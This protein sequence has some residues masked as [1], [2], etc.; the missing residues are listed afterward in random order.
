M[1]STPD[2]Q[3]TTA[4]NDG[5]HN[6]QET[7]HDW[8]RYHLSPFSIPVIIYCT[9]STYTT[10]INFVVLIFTARAYMGVVTMARKVTLQSII[11]SY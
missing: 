10:L 1:T 4:P 11:A 9:T 5:S 2:T 8:W 6:A 7:K 3:N